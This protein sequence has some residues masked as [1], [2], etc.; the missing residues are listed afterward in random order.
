MN[1]TDP[2]SNAPVNE[3][4]GN[5]AP[6]PPYPPYPLYRQHL[7]PS[8]EKRT[9][10]LSV[11]ALVLGSLSVLLALIGSIFAA[12]A[13]F[14]LITGLI[15]LVL[16]LVT[17]SSI[18]QSGYAPSAINTVSIILCASGMALS[19]IIFIIKSVMSYYFEM[20]FSEMMNGEYDY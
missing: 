15:G 13:I 9:S 12:A 1:N 6:Y 18:K 17:R 11:A 10:G 4:Y 2:R 5:Y 19:V 7:A 16:A 3:N 8:P 20:I 14:G